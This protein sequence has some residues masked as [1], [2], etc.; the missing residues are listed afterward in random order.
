MSYDDG[1]GFKVLKHLLGNVASTSGVGPYVHT[2]NRLVGPPFTGGAVPTAVALGCELD[3]EL[4]DAGPL[5]SRLLSGA[6]VASGTFAWNAGEEIVLDCDLI[7]RKDASSRPQ[8][9]TSPT[10]DLRDQ[11]VR[12]P[13]Q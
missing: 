11:P 1:A 5:Q 10:I 8:Q 12:P 7:G 13:S 9:L 2:L 6:R 4:P 3:Y